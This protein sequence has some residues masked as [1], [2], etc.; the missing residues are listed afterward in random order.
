MKIFVTGMAIGAV[1][2]VGY[3]F[4]VSAAYFT[5]QAILVAIMMAMLVKIYFILK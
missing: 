1:S 5:F 4:G 3:L 2:T